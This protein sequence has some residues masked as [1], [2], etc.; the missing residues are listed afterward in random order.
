MLLGILTCIAGPCG[1]AHAASDTGKAGGIHSQMLLKWSPELVGN[2]WGWLLTK[3]RYYEDSYK[4]DDRIFLMLSSTIDPTDNVLWDPLTGRGIHLDTQ[5]YVQFHEK[6]KNDRNTP[7]HQFPM[8]GSRN[9]ESKTSPG[10]PMCFTMFDNY[11]ALSDSASS[12]IIR[13]FYVARRMD[14]P[15]TKKYPVCFD[16]QSTK[17]RSIKVEFEEVGYQGFIPLPDGSMI[18][19]SLF[20]RGLVVIRLDENGQQYTSLGRSI[21]TLDAAT[22]DTDL[23]TTPGSYSDPAV[24]YNIF[25]RAIRA[26]QAP[27]QP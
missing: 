4:M 21:L 17:T 15:E 8:Y 11:F 24:R 2:Q 27:G 16:G 25:L 19:L 12:R 14:H 1:D 9:L 20:E 3:Y 13:A 18:F 23:R 10:V 6:H 7:L 5:E 26:A 22:I